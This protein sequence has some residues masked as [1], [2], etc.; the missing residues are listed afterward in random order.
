VGDVIR[1]GQG[2]A[3]AVRRRYLVRALEVLCTLPSA[4]PL[5]RLTSDA[6]TLKPTSQFTVS[7]SVRSCVRTVEPDT[8]VPVTV[9]VY[10]P[11]GVPGFPPPPPPPPGPPTPQAAQT[12]TTRIM[13]PKPILAG[14]GTRRSL[15]DKLKAS[16]TPIRAK[17]QAHSGGKTLKA[18]P[19]VGVLKGVRTTSDGAVVVTVTVAATAAS[20]RPYR[21]GCPW[22]NRP[23]AAPT[24]APFAQVSTFSTTEAA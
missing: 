19:F 16:R 9:R 17:A 12:V 3:E 23:G 18:R 13:S 4:S 2:G 11:N 5:E 6:R 10:V 14:T 24:L 1:A 21:A 7:V 22:W 20:R 15:L 8:E